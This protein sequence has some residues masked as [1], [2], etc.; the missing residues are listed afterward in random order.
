MKD[1]CTRI[2]VLSWLPCGRGCRGGWIPGGRWDVAI[3]S[4]F[5]SCC[6]RLFQQEQPAGLGCV[7]AYALVQRCNQRIEISLALSLW[8]SQPP[9]CGTYTPHTAERGGKLC[10]FSLNALNLSLILTPFPPEHTNIP[11]R[12]QQSP[13][14]VMT[15]TPSHPPNRSY[16]T[17]HVSIGNQSRPTRIPL[18]EG[19]QHEVGAWHTGDESASLEPALVNQA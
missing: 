12:P 7:C 4:W 1:G 17:T 10:R 16:T 13:Q 19:R 8:I 2:W 15:S 11:I 6:G 5:L 14:S 9:R 3:T 18:L